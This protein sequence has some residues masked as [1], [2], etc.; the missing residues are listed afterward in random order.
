M[1]TQSITERRIRQIVER[2]Q[3]LLFDHAGLAVRCADPG[4]AIRKYFVMFSGP[5]SF[6]APPR[7][8]QSP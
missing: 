4:K 1:V 8:V 7:D 5:S 6:E 3:I 2:H